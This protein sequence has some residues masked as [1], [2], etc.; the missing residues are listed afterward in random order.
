MAEIPR[1]QRLHAAI[2]NLD[3]AAEAET[4]SAGF[5]GAKVLKPQA[6]EM[7]L[8]TREATHGHWP[9]QANMIS[10][11]KTAMDTGAGGKGITTLRPAQRE[12]LELIA[13]KL[14]RILVGDPNHVDHWRDIAG[15][16]T[17]VVQELER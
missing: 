2:R 12:A 13:V 17:L 10:A 14:A 1:E 6:V 5:F 11:L 8:T 3:E 7:V 9:N 4:K 16:A 15:Y